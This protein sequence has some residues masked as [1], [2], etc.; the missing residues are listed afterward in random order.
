[1][2]N[3]IFAMSLVVLQLIM[4]LSFQ[5]SA[6]NMVSAE[7]KIYADVDLQDNFSDDILH[8]VLFREASGINLLHTPAEFDAEDI[9]SVEDMTTLTGDITKKDIDLENYRQILR[10]TLREKSKENVL[11]VMHRLE[12]HPDILYVGPNIIVK[13]ADAI[14][15]VAIHS[16][17]PF[18]NSMTAAWDAIHLTEAWEYATG[19]KNPTNVAILDYGIAYHEDLDDNVGQGLSFLFNPPTSQVGDA[20]ENAGHH[21]TVIAGI[22]GAV[23]NNN[24]GISGVCWNVN[25]IPMEVATVDFDL[26]AI[27]RAIQYCTDQHVPIITLCASSTTWNSIALKTAIENYPGLFVCTPGNWSLGMSD[28]TKNIDNVKRYPASFNLDNMLVVANLDSYNYDELHYTS[29]Y[30][31]ESV[32]LAAPGTN[33]Y[34]TTLNDSYSSYTMVGNKR[35]T[36]TGTSYAA[37]FVSGVAALIKSFR[38]QLKT[39][40]IKSCILNSVEKLVGL[41]DTTVSGGRLNAKGALQEASGYPLPEPMLLT[42]DVNGDGKDDLISI[43][44]YG[45]PDDGSIKVA[46][47]NTQN[48]FDFWTEDFPVDI[49]PEDEMV[50]GDIN[51]DGK[52]DIVLLRGSSPEYGKIKVAFSRSIGNQVVFDFWSWQSDTSKGYVSQQTMHTGDVNGDGKDDII[53]VGLPNSIYTGYIHIAISEGNTVKLWDTVSP[54]VITFE[55]QKVM[56]GDING[57]NKSDLLLV[58]PGANGYSRIFTSN[59]TKF[60]TDYTTQG[61][62]VSD[63]DQLRLAD[64]D[65]DG[66]LDFITATTDGYLRIARSNG[67][68]FSTWNYLS[69]YKMFFEVNG[70]LD[71]LY[72]ADVNGDGKT[73]ILSLDCRGYLSVALGAS[74]WIDE[75]YDWYSGQPVITTYE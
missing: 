5:T 2:K 56:V 18:N 6:E 31:K 13:A 62:Y 10:L 57:D 73:D 27:I 35:I 42:G 58:K 15:S 64:Q 69:R 65:G 19:V 61:I 47:G 40:E 53:L 29:N 59:G 54:G 70:I 1:M 38:P 24:T 66:R 33:I 41:E 8:V 63:G 21:G 39:A 14:D 67:S 68:G 36:H 74:S 34:S 71:R 4:A 37:P 50:L 46:L 25:M 16:N 28:T 20:R 23:A 75:M 3:R 45:Y 49:K 22:I 32:H 30:G 60:N 52:Q 72:T 51:G 7:A 17:D 9:A 26:D 48:G 12:K 43:G 44:R 55:F 11:R